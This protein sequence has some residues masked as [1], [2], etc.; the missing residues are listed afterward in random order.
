MTLSVIIVSYNTKELTLKCIKSVLKEKMD[1]EVIVVDNASTDGSVDAI[2]KI[3]EVKLL[4]NSQN[5][6]F[7][8]AN[9]QGIKIACGKYV[10]LLNSDAQVTPGSLK[11]LIDFAQATSDAGAVV[12]RL[13]NSD[14]TNQASVY[15]FPTYWRV[16]QQYIFGVRGLVDKYLPSMDR[17]NVV[18]V[19]TMAAYLLTP[20]AIKKIG[21]LDERYFMYFEDFD[22][23]RRIKE[24]NLKIYYLPQ[25]Q[26]IHT[27]GASG[28]KLAD[29]P[30]QWK[31]LIPSSKIYHG[32]VKHYLIN[33]I[34]WLNQK[35]RH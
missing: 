20:Q 18:E 19:A 10:L 11:K 6:G 28:R 7:A 23:A 31:R 1:L 30:D 13:I 16:F 35:L 25:A 5:S 3:K 29:E 24:K 14:G 32:I 27:H 15:R 9:N 4:K 2:E 22:Y 26:V 34:I 33:S 17:V 8:K 12:P 21:L